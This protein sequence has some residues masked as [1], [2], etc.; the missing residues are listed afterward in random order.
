MRDEVLGVAADLGR[1]TAMPVSE[2]AWQ[3]TVLE[4]AQ[5]YGWLVHHAR[6]AMNRS[7]RWSTPIQ[8]DAGFPDL[9]LAQLP[10]EDHPGRLIFA[11][12]KRDGQRL[13]PAQRVWRDA[14]LAAGHEWYLWRPADWREVE[15]VLAGRAAPGR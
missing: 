9:V 15:A 7:G 8:G 6:P 3:R 13:A 1:V 4:A 2:A 5:L 11:E 14:I 12:L 10:P